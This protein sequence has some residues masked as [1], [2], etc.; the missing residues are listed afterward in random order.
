MGCTLTL[1]CWQCKACRISISD[2]PSTSDDSDDEDSD[3]DSS[4]SGRKGVT[5]GPNKKYRDNRKTKFPR[6]VTD[7]S[8]RC[9]DGCG[10]TTKD[11]G[12]DYKRNMSGSRLDGAPFTCATCR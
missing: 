6:Y 8:G 4:G 1:G 12:K 7:A 3:E 2:V 5:W 11:R 10:G 9:S